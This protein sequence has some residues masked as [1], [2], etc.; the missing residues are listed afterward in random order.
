V[1]V[2]AQFELGELLPLVAELRS[3]VAP[4]ARLA[5][6]MRPVPD[7]RGSDVALQLQAEHCFTLP[8][9][10]LEIDELLAAPSDPE[11]GRLHREESAASAVP[12][13]ILVADDQPYNRLLLEE[14]LKH[15]GHMVELV[16]NGVQVL[17][18]LGR[19]SFDVLLMDMQMPELDGFAT[20]QRIRQR[21]AVAGG[22]LS[23]FMMSAGHTTADR[24]SCEPLE[25][26]GYIP[27]PMRRQELREALSK[28]A[29]DR[30]YAPVSNVEMPFT[31]AADDS[32]W[33]PR[34]ALELLDGNHRLLRRVAQAFCGEA[35]HLLNQ[36]RTA[37]DSNDRRTW[38]CV[39][40]GIKGA[41]Q[42][43][44]ADH[45]AR[46]AAQL[47]AFSEN[48][49]PGGQTVAVLLNDLIMQVAD[50]VQRLEELIAAEAAPIGTRG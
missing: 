32:H 50:V 29:A 39:A 27:K 8:L 22:H 11:S 1:L 49:S 48:S 42:T 15:D 14:W 40:H 21:E 19:A 2:D 12:L 36:L 25:I 7:D 13:R 3:A 10:L 26:N 45:A 31:E 30:T 35:P 34:R 47:E 4:P 33:N 24:T 28:L 20:A 37:V 16:E 44:G 5:L 6:L 17:E 46:T 41:M 9:T 38:K 23:I 43:L 18:A